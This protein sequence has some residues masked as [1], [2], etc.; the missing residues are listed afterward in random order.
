MFLGCR[1]YMPEKKQAVWEASSNVRY[2][3]K[4][5][6]ECKLL[7]ELVCNYKIEE[8]SFSLIISV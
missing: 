4:C 8:A 5:A 6:F 1:G 7:R 2:D 3:S